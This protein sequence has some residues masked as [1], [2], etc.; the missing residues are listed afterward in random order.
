MFETTIARE[1]QIAKDVFGFTHD[2]LKRAAMNSFRASFLP[3]QKKKEY[4]AKF[5]GRP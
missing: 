2:E 3:E 5:N 1:Y 4:L